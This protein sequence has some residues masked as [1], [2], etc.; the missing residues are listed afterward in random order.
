MAHLAE[1][2]SQALHSQPQ[3]TQT[4]KLGLLELATSLLVTR[5][6]A[7]TGNPERAAR[8]LAGD[9][10]RFFDVNSLAGFPPDKLDEAKDFLIDQAHEF[11]A[12]CARN[13]SHAGTQFSKLQRRR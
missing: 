7:L 12:G 11:I 4:E 10:E 6:L 9:L 2:T 1:T 5:S 3:L 8:R 13:P